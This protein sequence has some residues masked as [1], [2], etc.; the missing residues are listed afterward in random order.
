[1][2]AALAGLA[3]VS[4]AVPLGGLEG[5]HTRGQGRGET[6]LGEH[7]STEAVGVWLDHRDPLAGGGILEGLLRPEQGQ[8]KAAHPLRSRGELGHGRGL[9]RPVGGLVRA[10]H[11]Q[12]S[13]VGGGHVE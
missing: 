10:Q 4:V 7:V 8:V 12:G 9:A 13:H 11:D 1:V 3:G 6:A 5:L 2:D